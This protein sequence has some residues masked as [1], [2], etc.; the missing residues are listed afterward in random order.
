MVKKPGQGRVGEELVAF[1]VPSSAGNNGA[2]YVSDLYLHYKQ[3]LPHFMIPHRIYELAQLPTNNSGKIDRL[4]LETIARE[5][6][7]DA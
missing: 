1:I 2:I 7:P 3:H 5:R 4:Q 6:H